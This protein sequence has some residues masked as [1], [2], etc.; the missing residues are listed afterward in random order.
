MWVAGVMWRCRSRG[1]SGRAAVRVFWGWGLC[2]TE[3]FVAVGV[4]L[5]YWYCRYSVG[6]C[7]V[8][9]F[10]ASRVLPLARRIWLPLLAPAEANWP[11][12]PSPLPLVSSID[13]A[14]PLHAPAL[15]AAT[16]DCQHP[17][18]PTPASAR[19]LPS[20]ATFSC[21]YCGSM[22]TRRPSGLDS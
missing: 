7:G 11:L 4:A 5:G 10:P 16:A 21:G 20:V 14:S 22:A 13:G 3:S 2:G 15:F 6:G 12:M 18:P 17:R 1:W 8:G 9:I 19:P